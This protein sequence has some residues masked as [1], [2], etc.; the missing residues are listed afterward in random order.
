[1]D[2]EFASSP[3]PPLLEVGEAGATAASVVAGIGQ[4]IEGEDP[5]GVDPR[6]TEA[7]LSIE[8]EIGKI[9]GVELLEV[10]WPR[11]ESLAGHLLLTTSKDLRCGCYWTVAR[12]QV[13]QEQGLREG[14]DTLVALME[15]FGEVVFPRRAR[16]R[17]A[18]TVWLVQQLK[19][20]VTQLQMTRDE[21]SALQ[22]RVDKLQARFDALELDPAQIYAL[23]ELVGTI[24]LVASEEEREQEVLQAFPEGFGDIGLTL[25]QRSGEPESSMPTGLTLRMRR[26]ALWMALPPGEVSQRD[27]ANSK[28][29]QA[30]LNG[31]A[32]AGRW[33]DLLQASERAFLTSPFW[34]DLSYWSAKAAKHVVGEEGSAAIIGELRGLLARDPE[35]PLAVD[36]E[37]QELASSDVRAWIEE[38][39]MPK[40][41]TE[42]AEVSVDLPK[43]IA[44]MLEQGRTREAMITAQQWIDVSQGRVRFARCVALANS[45]KSMGAADQSFLVFRGLHGHLRSMTVKEWEPRL[46]AACLEG[47]LS[48]KK[49]S[50]GLGP[51]DDPLLEELSVLDP[52]AVLGVL[53]A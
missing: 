21:Q 16:G 40:G 5:S 1:M 25:L 22:E 11:V 4:P 31:M 46:F 45:F 15:G 44:E 26:W 29:A 2:G 10:N 18:A 12:V 14:L 13:A 23:R 8:E 19:A 20:P 50:L 35:L 32:S 27:I 51:E 41:Q 36:R 53:P 33:K 7:F 42:E 30:E 47:Y 49:A 28:E 39:V 37:G 48:S 3:E 17:L 38:A 24:K 6:L 9:G 52:T 43:D 34:L